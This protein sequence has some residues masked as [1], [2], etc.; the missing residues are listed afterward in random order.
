M[1]VS[2]G[3]SFRSR[4]PGRRRAHGFRRRWRRPCRW[5]F[6]HV[7]AE[8][9]PGRPPRSWRCRSRRRSRPRWLGLDLRERRVEESPVPEPAPFRD[10]ASP[11]TCDVLASAW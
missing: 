10:A 11:P 5:A 3:P 1:S 7:G 2:F 8:T 6:P 9:G 4:R